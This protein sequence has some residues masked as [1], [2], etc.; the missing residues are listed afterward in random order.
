MNFQIG[1]RVKVLRPQTDGTE[2]TP[3]IGQIV[4]IE[5][6]NGDALTG[7]TD[8]RYLYQVE[9]PDDE[10]SPLAVRHSDLKPVDRSVED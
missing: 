7:A 4:D 1:D 2:T 3:L 9:F 10:V 8:D 5:E 6:D